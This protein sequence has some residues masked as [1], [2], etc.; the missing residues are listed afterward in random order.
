MTSVV[1][2]LLII[3]SP[4]KYALGILLFFLLTFQLP[5]R[6]NDCNTMMIKIGRYLVRGVGVA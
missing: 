1:T 3:S 5:L 2:E 6:V 4:T